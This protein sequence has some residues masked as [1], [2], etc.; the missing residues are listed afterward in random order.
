VEADSLKCLDMP[1]AL[2]QPLGV[3]QPRQEIHPISFDCAGRPGKRRHLSSQMCFD[4]IP[5]S[6]I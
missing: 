2:A 6:L 1:E 5:S 3:E 4:C